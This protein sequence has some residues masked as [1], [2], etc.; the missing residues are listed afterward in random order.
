MITGRESAGA[1]FDEQAALEELERLQ[2][3]IEE[4][5]RQRGQTVEEF[6]AFV[7][8]F[9]NPAPDRD[10]SKPATVASVPVPT[11][12]APAPL[13]PPTPPVLAAP[14]PLPEI[15]A[16]PDPEPALTAALPPNGVPEPVVR[17]QVKRLGFPTL[18]AGLAAIAF[19]VV[20]AVFLLNRR[21]P[22]DAAPVSQPSQPIAQ[23]TAAPPVVAPP[24]ATPATPPM[25]TGGGL[26]TGIVTLRPVW[27]RVLVDG[28]RA[29]ERELRGNERIPLHAQRTIAIRAGDAGA[30]RVMIG[31]QD[32]GTLGRDGEVVSRT[33]TVQ[34]ARPQPVR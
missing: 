12:T 17:P 3:A 2:H 32:Q 11:P 25:Q 4:S 6:D 1:P 21:G 10:T 24:S 7:R 23:P 13:P 16:A 34:P 22:S 31:G 5:R 26:Q 19:V 9:K 14:P 28:E 15:V 8:S 30:L 20:A 33:F 18:I 27:V 29:V